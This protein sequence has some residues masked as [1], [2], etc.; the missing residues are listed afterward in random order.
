M[1]PSR[2]FVNSQ[3]EESKLH[4]VSHTVLRGHEAEARTPLAARVVREKGTVKDSPPYSLSPLA[5]SMTLA[6]NSRLGDV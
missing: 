4:A 3:I 5:T 1:T 2:A 6:S